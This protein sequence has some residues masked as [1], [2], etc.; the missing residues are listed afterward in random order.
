MTTPFDQ[1]PQPVPPSEGMND[2]P[3]DRTNNA[4]TVPNAVPADQP[5]VASDGATTTP[6][7]PAAAPQQPAGAPFDRVYAVSPQQ[8][9]QVIHDQL[10]TGA[11]FTLDNENSQTGALS[12]HS[13]DG[14]NCML[15]VVPQGAAG[16]AIRLEATG[17]ESAKRVDEFLAS[18]DK[19]I[20]VAPAPATHG[21]GAATGF[22]G[23]AAPAVLA[24]N[25]QGVKK[26]SKLAVFAIIW[27]VLFVLAQFVDV[28]GRSWGGLLFATVIP[29]LLSGFA[30]YV[31]R[32]SGKVQGRVLA[33]VAVGITVVGLVIGGVF[34]IRDGAEASLA[35]KCEAY[36]W[37][38]SD[39]AALL[40]Q[41]KS[42]KGEIKSE[43]SDYF[44]IQVCDT[45]AKQ[46]ADYVKSVQDNGFTVDYDKSADIFNA[47]NADGYSVSVSR[48][49]DN[50]T[51]MSITIQAPKKKEDASTD[52]DA[53]K[54]DDKS[55]D[56][57]TDSSDANKQSD[58]SSDQ[59]AQQNTN[60][61]ADFKSTM[62]SY[63][64]FIDE[65]VA[66]MNK[67]QKSDNVVSM[68]TD[69]AGMMKRYSEFS[70]KV[71][72]IDESSLSS[73]DSAYY[74]EVMTRCTQKLASVGQ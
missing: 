48:D 69:Y 20:G 57:G 66:F 11:T 53:A 72:A 73:E 34:V 44:F 13:Y 61:N 24:P 28:S 30:V 51:I 45:D 54:Q 27:G 3:E 43:S 16:T 67:Y 46:Y 6:M 21:A 31:T 12:F 1:Q 70:Q 59:K 49:T 47:K 39:I 35:T 18:L 7:T 15:T 50:E 36:S 71:D 74:T 65:Y 23:A 29:A 22:A 41:P 4:P 63:E 38:E 60:D 5:D 62:D 56:T 17:N 52:G 2:G 10:T 37:P 33:W 55:T 68:A 40:P 14:V 19:R 9:F 58:Q 64:A 42:T 8:L 25:A 26:T 32:P